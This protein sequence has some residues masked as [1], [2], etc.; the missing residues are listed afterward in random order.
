MA[1]S[2]NDDDNTIVN[3]HDIYVQQVRNR[4][5][6]GEEEETVD[7]GQLLCPLSRQALNDAG[8]KIN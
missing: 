6:S 7:K 5:E 2:T 8:R 4:V 1:S 3:Y